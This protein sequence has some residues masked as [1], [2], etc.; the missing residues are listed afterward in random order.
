MPPRPAKKSSSRGRA[1][2]APNGREHGS[3]QHVRGEHLFMLG[4]VGSRVLNIN[5][6]LQQSWH[7]LD[8]SI[9]FLNF[10]DFSQ[11]NH[12]NSMRLPVVA[13]PC[14]VSLAAPPSKNRLYKG[15]TELKMLVVATAT[16]GGISL[17]GSV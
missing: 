5:M 4:F 15:G 9:L 2:H 17:T 8:H 6:G 3:R 12:R 10:E 11:H 13:T 16:I 14:C 1:S 7:L